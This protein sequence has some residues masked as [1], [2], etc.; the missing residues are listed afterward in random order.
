M[1]LKVARMGGSVFALRTLVG[2]AVCV[3]GEDVPSERRM[4]LSLVAALVTLVRVLVH[5]PCYFVST[6]ITG[7][8]RSIITHITLVRFLLRM[9]SH[10]MYF[11][12]EVLV[13]FVFAMRTLIRLFMCVVH[14]DVRFKVAELNAAIVTHITLEWLVLGTVGK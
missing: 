13:G 1:A 5:M 7:I 14:H 6:Q 11:Q 12:C 4:S 10:H 2:F 8:C 9:I 3:L